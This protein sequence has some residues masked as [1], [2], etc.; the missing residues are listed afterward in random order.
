MIENHECVETVD[1]NNST[2]FFTKSKLY[3]ISVLTYV[4][5]EDL[6]NQCRKQLEA[7]LKYIGHIKK[8]KDYK[9]VIQETIDGLGN[10]KMYAEKYITKLK[11]TINQRIRL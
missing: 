11:V 9:S 10:Q 8:L 6:K 4:E 2:H 5:I 3:Y 7:L 1:I